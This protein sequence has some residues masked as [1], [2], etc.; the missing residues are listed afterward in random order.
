MIALKLENITKHFGETIAVTDFNLEVKD[1]EFIVFV[2]PSGCG[3]TTTLRLIAGLEEPTEGQI[4]I[5]ENNIT[6]VTPNKRNIA[7]VFQ[8]YALYPNKTVFGNLAFGLK[9]QKTPKDIIKKKVGAAAEMLQIS[10]LL[11][12]KPAQLSG[13]EKQRVAMGRAVV[14]DPSVFLFDEPLSNLDAKLR[15]Q[16]RTEIMKLHREVK[17]AVVYVTHDLAEAMTLADRIVIMKDGLIQQI[18][19]PMDIYNHPQNSFVASFIGNPPMNLIDVVVKQNGKHQ[20]IDFGNNN[21]LLIKDNVIKEGKYIFGIRPECVTVNNSHTNMVQG[22]VEFIEHL[23]DETLVHLDISK[24]RIVIKQRSISSIKHGDIV[25]L[26]FNK[27][28]IH[29]FSENEG[30][31]ISTL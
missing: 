3:K 4:F 29:L 21:T 10:H 16:M 27:N 5:G 31:V 2:G 11:K 6:N 30:E 24:S 20:V 22:Q 8:N 25:N 18:G 17:T 12:R 13:G 15:L 28:K 19:E 9:V 14:R 23:G 26:S 1:N 7:M